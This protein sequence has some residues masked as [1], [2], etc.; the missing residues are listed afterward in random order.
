MFRVVVLMKGQPPSLKSFV[1]LTRFPSY[2][3]P[4][5]PPSTLTTFPV[6]REGGQSCPQGR[7]SELLRRRKAST[8]YDGATTVF[9]VGNGGQLPVEVH[10]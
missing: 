2:L 1:V 10:C 5:I 6:H 7:W 4:S 9:H 3:A 8:Q